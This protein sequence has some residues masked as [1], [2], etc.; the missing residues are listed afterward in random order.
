MGNHTSQR[1]QDNKHKNNNLNQYGTKYSHDASG[2]KPAP[3]YGPAPNYVYPTTEW[4]YTYIPTVAAGRAKRPVI[5]VA[6]PL[7]AASQFGG[8]GGICGGGGGLPFGGG[9]LPFGG[10]GGLPFGG[11]L[12]MGGSGGGL[13]FGFGGG[14]PF[15]GGLPFKSNF[16]RRR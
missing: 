9:G 7:P 11:G 4:T 5:Y 13:P 8:F 3:Y 15:A 14:A 1:K 2:R 16:P 6:A 12:Q 10:G